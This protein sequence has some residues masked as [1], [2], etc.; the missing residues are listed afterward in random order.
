MDEAI[1]NI[2][3]YST[4]ESVS[5]SNEQANV[6]FI[7]VLTMSISITCTIC[8]G[9]FSYYYC[10][11]TNG[12]TRTKSVF[13]L[14][15]SYM[16]HQ[17]SNATSNGSEQ[18]SS[19]RTSN[20]SIIRPARASFRDSLRLPNFRESIWKLMGMQNNDIKEARAELYNPDDNG[21]PPDDQ[22]AKWLI[23]TLRYAKILLEYTEEERYSI[24]R[25][26]RRLVLPLNHVL[27]QQGSDGTDLYI[28]ERGQLDVFVNGDKVNTIFPGWAFGELGFLF[29]CFR[30]ATCRTT[31]KS[32]LWVLTRDDLESVVSTSCFEPLVVPEQYPDLRDGFL[33]GTSVAIDSE[34]DPSSN[35]SSNFTAPWLRRKSTANTVTSDASHVSL[36]GISEKPKVKR[37]ITGELLNELSH[38]HYVGIPDVIS[39]TLES[40]MVKESSPSNSRRMSQISEV[41]LPSLF[42]ARSRRRSSMFSSKPNLELTDSGM[43]P[44]PRESIVERSLA[45]N[46]LPQRSLTVDAFLATKSKSMIDVHSSKG[47][48]SFKRQ[49]LNFGSFGVSG[50]RRSSLMI[51]V[52]T[53]KRSNKSESDLYSELSEKE[54][55]DLCLFE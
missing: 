16:A 24:V 52:N 14:S 20:N 26:M 48:P 32:T 29:N 13:R 28:L 30:S 44:T 11:C 49:S 22:Q 9:V 47:S 27:I 15:M 6:V 33:K 55:N 42:R 54:K 43:T 36:P 25:K 45:T 17:T 35:E 50:R 4:L 37:M 53:S 21:T 31:K 5:E 18:Q 23:G 3:N 34:L 2:S 19:P 10:Y 39:E 41:N 8:C 1:Y 46:G 40:Y 7:V 12:T 38:S 51:M